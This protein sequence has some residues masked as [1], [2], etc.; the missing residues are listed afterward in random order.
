M[1]IYTGVGDKG[2][3]HLFGG[4]VVS[5]SA[6]CIETYGTLDELNSFLGLLQSKI[7]NA[8]IN[9]LLEKLQSQVFTLSSEIATSDEIQRAKFKER[10]DADDIRFLEE[11]IDHYS[12]KLPELKSFILPGGGEAGAL[13]HVARTICRRAER[14]LIRWAQEETVEKQW[15]VYLNRLSDLLFVLARFLNLLEGK[16]ETTWKG[17]R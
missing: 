7:N 15:V 1:K 16:Q 10:I 2:T 4:K 17:L 12:E 6:L 3:T 9:K 5:K 14:N 8:E 11:T 13:C